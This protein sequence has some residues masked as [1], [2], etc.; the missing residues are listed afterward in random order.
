[1]TR[2]E[3]LA[4]LGVN[5]AQLLT[6]PGIDITADWQ[7]S[8][9]AFLL[10]LACLIEQSNLSVKQDY[11]QIFGNNT[12][13]QEEFDSIAIVRS[14]ALSAWNSSTEE[15][16]ELPEYVLSESLDIK[17]G[18]LP[19]LLTVPHDGTIKAYDGKALTTNPR[20]KGRDTASSYIAKDIAGFLSLLDFEKPYLINQLTNRHYLTPQLETYFEEQTLRTLCDMSSSNNTRHPILHL[21][22]HGFGGE[23]PLGYAD[24]IL[25]TGHRTTIRGTDVDHY[26]A[27]FMTSR[28]Y[29]VYMP[30]DDYIE[31]EKFMADNPQTLIQR[32]GSLSLAN[33]ISM[34][35][36][37]GSKFR[38][39]DAK[40]EGTALSIDISE[41][42][43]V[44]ESLK[45]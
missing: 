9:K 24:I 44:W 7:E 43:I 22:I 15:H 18:E 29:V 33:V 45:T 17:S 40:K 38:A 13:S 14:D 35:I 30:G 3:A 31:G 37:I 32:V 16:T 26:F 28:G 12:I 19:V 36:E 27:D 2:V 20:A 11:P 25:G 21:D 6:E 10:Y 8:D 34:Q 1:M 39:K 42:L 23:L 4:T 41:F 5:A